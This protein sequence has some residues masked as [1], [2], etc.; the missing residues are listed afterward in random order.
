MPNPNARE[1]GREGVGA[2]RA[3][4]AG[5]AATGTLTALAIAH[6]PWWAIFVAAAGGT[7]VG[8]VQMVFP[9]D[10]RDRLDWWRDRRRYQE[11]RRQQAPGRRRLLAS[12]SPR[13]SRT[14]PNPGRC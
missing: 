3:L 5:T 10:S 9:Q 4:I 14:L 11:R 13:P 6:A 1:A 8:V 2:A 7:A 12:R